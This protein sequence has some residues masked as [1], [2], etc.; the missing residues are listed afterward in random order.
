MSIFKQQNIPRMAT[1]DSRREEEEEEGL[2][3][4]E[5]MELLLLV[6]LVH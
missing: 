5:S 4:G 2:I 6:Y 3:E 1:F